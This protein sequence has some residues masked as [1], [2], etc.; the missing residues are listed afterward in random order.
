MV[1]EVFNFRKFEPEAESDLP[2]VIDQWNAKGV[3]S[4]KN[5]D[6]FW[7]VVFVSSDEVVIVTDPL[8]KKPFYMR[9]VPLAFSS[10]IRP[11]LTLG[12][13]HRD[14]VYMS[15]VMKWGYCPLSLTPYQEIAKVPG[16]AVIRID[17][18]RKSFAVSGPYLEFKR[19]TV[20]PGD[21]RSALERSV[22]NRLVSD[23]PVA[24]LAS[25]GLDSSIVALLAAAAGDVTVFHVENDEREYFE[26]L[27]FAADD[28]IASLVGLGEYPLAAVVEANQSP[29]DM[30]SMAPQFALGKAV[31]K[32]GF[33]VALSGDGADELFGGY[34]RAMEYD[35]QSSDIFHELVYYHLPRLDTL[36][37]A[38]TVELRC[39][40]LSREVTELAMSLPWEWRKSKEILKQ[41]FQGIVPKMILE[42]EKKPLRVADYQEDRMRW[43]RTVMETFLSVTEKYIVK[44]EA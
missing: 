4:F 39:P 3:Q 11:L 30:G 21:I 10:E 25:G 44:E 27:P 9:T 2:V 13:V 37:M 43:R 16:N 33:N 19:R 38:S 31:Q 26:A 24:V 22:K 29:V 12:P 34:R 14:P 15:T 5:Y 40:F 23:L 42:R 35:S 20:R 17:P 32:R 18:R 36:M 41:E 7:T 6:G 1:G 28:R 8:A